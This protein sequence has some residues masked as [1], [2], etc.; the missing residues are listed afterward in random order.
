MT[1]FDY[2]IAGQAFGLACFVFGM[3]IYSLYQLMEQHF[4]N[5]RS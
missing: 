1:N 2:F 5:K 3:F 4:R